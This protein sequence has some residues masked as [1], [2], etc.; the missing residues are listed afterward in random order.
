MEQVF[1][2]PHTKHW[3][4]AELELAIKKENIIIAKLSQ[5]CKKGENKDRT[6]SFFYS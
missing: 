3:T 5:L 2:L 6:E 1:I 4:A